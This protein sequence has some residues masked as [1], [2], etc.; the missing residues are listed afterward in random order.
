MNMNLSTI[1]IAGVLVLA[2]VLFSGA[3]DFDMPS[4][5]TQD[6]SGNSCI[7]EYELDLASA[8]VGSIDDD[9]GQWVWYLQ[10]ADLNSENITS[11]TVSV[12]ARRT[13]DC[14]SADG[15]SGLTHIANYELSVPSTY[16]SAVDS[17]DNNNYHLL[18]YD[19]GTKSYNVTIDGT[20]IDDQ[21]VLVSTV[22]G[23]TNTDTL[24]VAFEDFTQY[25]EKISGAVGQFN[26]GSVDFA[27]QEVQVVYMKN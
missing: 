23:G 1:L 16:K 22:T 3:V 7:A 9:S 26:L 27:G 17:S 12:T 18:L 14:V 8:S 24:A 15:A 21:K 5:T 2:V 4:V 10:S 11:G 13:D 6:A 25:D 19:E 20:N